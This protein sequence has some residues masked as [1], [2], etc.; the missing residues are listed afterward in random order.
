MSN[1]NIEDIYIG[2]NNVYKKKKGKKGIIIVFF[3]LFLILAGLVG[4]YYYFS[5][6][7]LTK[8]QLFVNSISNT[9][10]KTFLQN[11]IY[12]EI[13]NRILAENSE[14]ETEI[15][16]STSEENEAL[17]GVDLS[18]FALNLNT[19][20]DIEKNKGF[21]EVI[22][23]YSGNE[24]FKVRALATQDAVAIAS[25]EIVNKYVGIH[26][27]K[28]S[29][30]FG[31][32]F[33]KQEIENLK[34][35]ENI[36]LSEEE[37]NTYLQKYSKIILDNIPEE[38]FSSQENIVINKNNTSVD[39]ISYVLTLNQEEL[40]NTMIN[41]LTNLR[42]DEEL[43]GKLVTGNSTNVIKETNTVDEN[44]VEE[45]DVVPSFQ[46]NTTINL[47]DQTN[48]SAEQVTEEHYNSSITL[49]TEN[50]ID[51]YNTVG[52]TNEVEVQD[53]IDLNTVST[54]EIVED[55][56]ITTEED[57]YE[58]LKNLFAQIIIGKKVDKSVK[59]LQSEIDTII[60]NLKNIKGE[61]LKIT[62]YVNLENVTEKISIS[63]PDKNTIDLEFSSN[64][65][66]N[67][68]IQITY[69]YENV[70]SNNILNNEVVTY[71]AE[72]NI[73][74]TEITQSDTVQKDGIKL[75]INKVT[76]DA[77]NTLKINSSIIE[78]EEINKKINIE[79]KTNGTKTASNITNDIVIGVSTNENEY[80]LLLD[81]T[82][83]FSVTPEI[84]YL[85]DE[86]CLFIE[87]LSE[88]ERDATMQAIMAQ[89]LKVYQEKKEGLSLIDTNTNSSVI[90]QNLANVS[91]T[92]T[93]EDAKNALIQKVSN[94]M[95]EAQNN[96]QEFTIQNLADL[97]IDGFEVSSTISETEAIIVVDTYTFK[98]NTNFELS[99]V[100]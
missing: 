20:N 42:N 90:Q 43:L 1:G 57:N 10:I 25:D 2:N 7:T 26:Y 44:V 70:E 77:S 94:M 50:S 99:E 65:E 40:N 48:S 17:E 31:I 4:A 13:T 100:E 73:T 96:N 74:N 14:T 11:D 8:K 41:L 36:N 88:E 89:I 27:D 87:N 6:Q 23:N 22:L 61:G 59:D 75:E 53:S 60:T 66:N 97:Q 91:S 80:K 35:S 9:N 62:V 81:N 12:E 54:G 71:S 34:N 95:G 37:K 32:D 93:K 39:V 30:V 67:N 3:I 92:V 68:T 64:G 58:E 69:L 38:K 47:Y 83:R 85:T 84:E 82:I 98:I 29:E 86:N 24:I 21:S 18:N 5:N 33:D 45:N 46:T 51:V 52:S 28:I 15:K 49:E 16:F 72:D 78:K 63:L 55:I 79:I 76:S 56:D 19:K